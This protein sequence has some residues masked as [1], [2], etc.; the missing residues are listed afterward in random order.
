ML[1]GGRGVV[2][3]RE[4]WGLLLKGG[5]GRFVKGGRGGLLFKRVGG[6]KIFFSSCVFG[7]GFQF[8]FWKEPGL[9]RRQP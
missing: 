2:V 8:D 9:E 1:K 6:G 3:K 5:G 7:V 4:G